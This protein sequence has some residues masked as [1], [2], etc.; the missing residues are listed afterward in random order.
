METVDELEKT[1]LEE[2]EGGME[3]LEKERYKNAV[4]LLS[5]SIFALCDI[6]I[7]LKLNKLP[8]NHNERFRIL[9]EYF[10][11][12]YSIVDDSIVDDVFSHYTD[13]Y[14]KPILK[15]TCDK[16]KNAIQQIAENK[17]LPKRIKEVIK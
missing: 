2:Y 4:I 17:G 7:Y 16:I 11:D 12:V 14:S 3:Q 9:E 13:A 10:K 1:F 6:V 8:K 15:E 5:K